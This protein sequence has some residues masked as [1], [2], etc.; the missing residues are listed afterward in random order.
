MLKKCYLDKIEQ[1][2]QFAIKAHKAHNRIYGEDKQP[3]EFHLQMVEDVADKF[4]HLLPDDHEVYVKV[5]SGIWVHDIIEMDCDNY[6]GIKQ[7][8]GVDVAELSFVLQPD[9]GR[10][11]DERNSVKMYNRIKETEYATFIKLCDRIANC[12]YSKRTG[13]SMFKKYK[14]EN[15]RFKEMLYDEKYKAMFD[16]LDELLND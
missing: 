10:N 12:T 11:R 14:K 5:Y 8:L 4:N 13:T 6:N 15:A 7:I 3:Y 1:A 2:R 9:Q 16:Y